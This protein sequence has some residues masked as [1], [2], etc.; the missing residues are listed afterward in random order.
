MLYGITSNIQ[1]NM[2]LNKGLLEI[3]GI[4]VP[5]TIMAN[6]K[7][8][9]R[10]RA[11]REGLFFALAFLAPFVFLPAFNKGFLKLN[12]ISDNMHGCDDKIMHMSKKYLTKD[13][14]YLEEGMSK[15]L[16]TFKDKKNYSEISSSFSN[17][18][19]KFPDRE[20]LRKKL[21]NTHSQVLIS[22]F[23]VSGLMISSIPWLSN[24]ITKIKTGKAGFSAKFK[25]VDEQTL[26]EDAK[27]HEQT[28]YKK[29]GVIT[30]SILL[31]GIGLYLG[32]KK[33]MLAGNSSKVGNFIKKHSAKFDYKDGIFMSR[34]ILLLITLCA[35]TPSTILS[36]RD[37]EE[38]K[39]NTI[40]N[41][42]LNGIF[43]GG[44]IILNNL[45]ARMLDKTMGTKL[46][47]TSKVEKKNTFLNRITCPLKTFKEIDE[48]KLKLDEQTLRKTKKAGVGMF[49]GNFIV[50]CG[51]LGFGLPYMLNK[52]LKQDV[53][54]E[55]DKNKNNKPA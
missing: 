36:S 29:L 41:L 13:G 46:L 25:M 19:K 2:V 27:K 14:R 12:K 54:R 9:A 40:K 28:K 26:N 5:N 33:G 38:V 37:K 44:D 49:W 42:T 48:N 47:D 24:L 20:V 32:L 51:I 3:G 18:L 53:A 35:D 7:T 22:D 6:N 50:L 11:E 55:K 34:T 43:F 8:E 52:I 23:I 45:A 21:I 31:S 4:A 1:T 15:L 39:Y 17:I 16:N 10:E 30:G